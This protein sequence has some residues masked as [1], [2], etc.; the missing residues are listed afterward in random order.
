MTR[1]EFIAREQA[2]SR[3]ERWFC[4]VWL[5]SFFALLCGS[6]PLTAW[7]SDKG[8][9]AWIAML[10]I[11]GLFVFLFGNLLLL[12]VLN[13]ARMKKHGLFCPYCRGPLRG[14]SAQTAIATGNCGHCGNS[15]FAPEIGSARGPWMRVCIENGHSAN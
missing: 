6:V 3:E 15:L 4:A 11:V 12:H 13:R 10:G 8:A 9:P 7:L 14:S 5:V 2:A 1:R